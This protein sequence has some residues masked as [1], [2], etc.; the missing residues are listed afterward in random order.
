M[1]KSFIGNGA[2]E[3]LPMVLEKISPQNILIFTLKNSFAQFQPLLEEKLGTHSF[4]YYSDI[5]PN[6]KAFEV[7]KALENITQPFDLIIAFGGGSVI[8]FAKL[9]KVTKDNSCSVEQ[10]F[11]LKD[12]LESKTPLI[13]IPTTFGTGSEATQFAVVY[14]NGEKFS[15]DTKK[16]LP[17]FAIVDPKLSLNSPSYLKACSAMDAFAQAMESF[18]CVHSTK[19]SEALSVKALEL[20]H[21]HIVDYVNTADITVA[22]QVAQASH[23]AGE[24]INITRTTVAH[25]LSYKITSLYG[26]PHGHAVALTLPKIFYHYLQAPPQSIQ[27]PRG[28]TQFSQKMKTLMTTL[29]LSSSDEVIPYF[30]NLYNSIGLEYSISKL[31]INEVKTIV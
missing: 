25:A 3:H 7:E 26:V 28:F 22:E 9:F 19:E 27:D 15:L 13:A 29:N 31:N 2:L 14:I 6:T 5:S 8:D 20:L 11:H 10:C 12:N 18:W 30:T 1:Q 17:E 16:I 4:F 24:A 23:W 21:R